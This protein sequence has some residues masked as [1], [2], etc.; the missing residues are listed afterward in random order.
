MHG[1][2]DIGDAVNRDAPLNRGLVSWWLALPDQQRGVMFRD[3][4]MRNHGT[5]TNG[6]TWT[7][8]WGLP[9]SYGAINCDGTNDYIVANSS[10]SLTGL[11]T[12]WSVV[13]RARLDTIANT[14]G[15]VSH[16]NNSGGGWT[17]G[18]H[19]AVLGGN[20]A[21]Y[22]STNWRNSGYTLLDSLDYFIGVTATGTT[23][24][25]HVR[26]PGVSHNGTDVYAT[27]SDANRG[28]NLG[29]MWLNEDAHY[30]D[31]LMSDVA[32]FRRALS[33]AEFDRRYQASRLG[34]P[35]ELNW[36]QRPV[37]SAQEAA[38]SAFPWHYYQMMAG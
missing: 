36:L 5:L 8:S 1:H 6:P 28:I 30:L 7:G 34:Y 12:D 11:D 18:R 38:A 27:S 9:G 20:L 3:L 22:D 32:I 29:R 15:F 13:F 23:L 10:S 16:A 2:I 17:I 33:Q 26:A 19:F 21:V 25:F 31:G 24:R 37:V 4:M 35:N 14:F